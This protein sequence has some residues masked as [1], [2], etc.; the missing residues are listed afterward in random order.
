MT[1]ILKKTKET[2]E[3][4]LGGKISNGVMTIPTSF[5]DDQRDATNNAAAQAGLH[6]DRFMLEPVAAGVDHE[7]DD[8]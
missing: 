1:C 8:D 4:Y 6:I 3:E 5:G 7:T 2:A